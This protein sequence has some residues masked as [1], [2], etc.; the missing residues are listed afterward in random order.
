[1]KVITMRDKIRNIPSEFGRYRKFDGDGWRA[2]KNR[3]IAARLCALD[4]EKAT[5]QEVNEIIGDDHWTRLKCYECGCEAEAVVEVGE[6]PDYETATTR[7]CRECATK[8]A[9]LFA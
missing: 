1:M 6:P 9:A 3:E 7:L 5:A 4:T 2:R 8:A